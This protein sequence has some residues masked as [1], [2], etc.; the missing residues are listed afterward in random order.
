MSRVTKAQ[1]AEQERDKERLREM[2]KPGDTVYTVLRHVSRS[3]M[4][5]VID[6]L[7]IKDNEPQRI[8]GL[9]ADLLEGYDSRHRGAKASGC[10]MDTGF[11]LVYNLSRVLNPGGFSCIGEGCPSN[12]H[13]NRVEP[14]ENACIGEMC[15]NLNCADW[16]HSDGGYALRQRWM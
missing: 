11:H 9:A 7:V 15:S 13:S 14:P 16:I 5:R 2:V 1:L 10:G 6:L 3:G 4:Y 12:D 8:T